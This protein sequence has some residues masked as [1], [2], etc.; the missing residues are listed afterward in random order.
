MNQGSFI[1]FNMA[2]L[3][4]QIRIWIQDEAKM[5]QKSDIIDLNMLVNA[6]IEKKILVLG[7]WRP[8]SNLDTF[9]FMD[10]DTNEL[11]ESKADDFCQ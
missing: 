9:M 2:K 10:V 6:N 7:G 8:Y 3:T 1:M 4:R 5:N 11:K